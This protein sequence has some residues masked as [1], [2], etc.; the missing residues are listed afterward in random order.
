MLNEHLLK[1]FRGIVGPEKILSE[2]EDLKAYSYYATTNWI[3]EPDLV[4]F[5]D[6]ADEIAE[7]MRIANANKIPVTPRGGGSCLSGGPVPIQGGIV[8]CTSK[9]NKILE[10]DKQGMTAT[11]EPGVVLFDLNAQRT[12]SSLLIPKAFLVQ[13]WVG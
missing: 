9:M 5:A 6:K 10:I 2:R 12:F 8:L 11:V 4:I 13:R 3:R 7:I 1:Q